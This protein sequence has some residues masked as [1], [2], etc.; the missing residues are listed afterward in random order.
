MH[1]PRQLLGRSN[2]HLLGATEIH[3]PASSR[4]L[5]HEVQNTSDGGKARIT[6]DKIEE[7]S[8]IAAAANV[9][10]ETAK[11]GPVPNV[12]SG[13]EFYISAASLPEQAIAEQASN[14]RVLLDAGCIEKPEGGVEKVII[15]EGTGD[16]AADRVVS[17]VDALESLVAQAEGM[18]PSAEKSLENSP[19][20]AT[21]AVGNA[22]ADATANTAVDQ[23]GN[24]A[25]IYILSGFPEKAMGEIV[26][27]DS[28]NMN[29]NG[30]YP[31]CRYNITRDYGPGGYRELRPFLRIPGATRRHPRGGF[32]FW[33][34]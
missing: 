21:G 5:N 22:M 16:F 10:R 33:L 1:D 26:F 28:D 6:H 17:V 32:Q 13:V 24:E 14:W 2:N 4:Y 3:N 8:D 7:T 29:T 15:G 9:F 27:Y 11:G 25:L 20:A 18:I 23:S 30:I 19:A 34:R 31:T 12:A